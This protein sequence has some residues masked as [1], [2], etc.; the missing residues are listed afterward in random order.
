MVNNCQE[1]K[2]KQTWRE[3][4]FFQANSAMPKCYIR[5]RAHTLAYL[6]LQ[7]LG[8]VEKPEK[9]NLLFPWSLPLAG[10]RLDSYLCLFL[11]HSSQ[12]GW[13]PCHQPKCKKMTG[14]I[15]TRKLCCKTRLLF[16]H[17]IYSITIWEIYMDFLKLFK[18]IISR[19]LKGGK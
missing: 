5:A 3:A 2:D 10:L 13:Y 12:I 15:L 16:S 18:V 14:Y 8:R 17:R 1:T 6:S 19:M 9:T 7:I 11:S 4:K